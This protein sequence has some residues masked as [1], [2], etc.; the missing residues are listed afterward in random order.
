MS[1]THQS[2]DIQCISS[3]SVVGIL[4]PIF[5]RG[6]IQTSVDRQQKA[7][8]TPQIPSELHY[9]ELWWYLNDT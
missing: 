1:Y 9:K 3:G 4:L 6:K 5:T 2:K 8:E 7:Y